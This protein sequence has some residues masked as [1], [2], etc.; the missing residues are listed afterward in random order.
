[1]AEA[2]PDRSQ[3]EFE[4]TPGLTRVML[5]PRRRGEDDGVPFAATMVATASE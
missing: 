4:A 3:A 1:M 2:R 5:G